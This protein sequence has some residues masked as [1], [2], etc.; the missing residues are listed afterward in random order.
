MDYF[1][2]VLLYFIDATRFEKE[3]HGQKAVMPR[4]SAWNR[5]LGKNAF[6]EQWKKDRWK[7]SYMRLSF[8]IHQYKP[9]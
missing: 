7:Y 2:Q 5:H 6:F 9:E 3:K 1:I 4:K 8:G